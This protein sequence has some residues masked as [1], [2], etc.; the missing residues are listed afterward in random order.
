MSER[1]EARARVLESLNRLF[2]DRGV[3]LETLGDDDNLA[4]RLEWDSMD[5]VDLSLEFR[6]R[7]GAPIPEDLDQINTI[8]RLTQWVISAESR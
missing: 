8:A 5:V 3:P 2:G 7:L 4:Q 6:R 1:P